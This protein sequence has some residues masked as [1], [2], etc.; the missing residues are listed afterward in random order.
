MD[1][2]VAIVKSQLKPG[3]IIKGIVGLIIIAAI[4]DFFGV[5]NFLL[6]PVSALK[7]KFGK[8]PAA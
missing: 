7:A 5:T 3:T 8:A 4:A 2:P 6:Y 1:N